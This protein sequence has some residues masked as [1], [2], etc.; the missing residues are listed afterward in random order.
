MQGITNTKRTM[1]RLKKVQSN[2]T[3]LPIVTSVNASQH[4]GTLLYFNSYSSSFTC[5]VFSPL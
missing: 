5:T 2:L 3:D 1:V 4:I